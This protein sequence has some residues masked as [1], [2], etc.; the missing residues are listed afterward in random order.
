MADPIK[1]ATSPAPAPAKPPVVTTPEPPTA[2]EVQAVKVDHEKLI[3]DAMEEERK[4]N[5]LNHGMKM[6]FGVFSDNPRKFRVMHEAVGMFPSG[7]ILSYRDLVQ[8][9]AKQGPLGSSIPDYEKPNVTA[10]KANVDRLI[11]L[12]AIEVVREYA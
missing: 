12:G 7:K 1:P 2:E 5:P 9:S 10:T 8:W 6:N 4:A 3:A 11:G